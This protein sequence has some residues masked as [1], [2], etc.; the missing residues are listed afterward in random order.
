[1][2]G[3]SKFI[4]VLNIND[5]CI[6]FCLIKKGINDKRNK[7]TIGFTYSIFIIYLSGIL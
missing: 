6:C 1:M 7:I 5:L 2:G 3:G 4:N